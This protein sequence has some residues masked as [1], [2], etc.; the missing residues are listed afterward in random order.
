MLLCIFKELVQGQRNNKLKHFK[1]T[2]ATFAL[3]KAMFC[4]LFK[5]N[6]TKCENTSTPNERGVEV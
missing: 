3:A 1:N 6:I 2:Y 4:S 5:P